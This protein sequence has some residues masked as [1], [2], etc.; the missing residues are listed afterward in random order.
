MSNIFSIHNLARPLSIVAFGPGG[1]DSNDQEMMISIAQADVVVAL[2]GVNLVRLATLLSPG[3][4]AL[5][6]LS[7]A[8]LP[9][10]PPDPFQ[11]L[12]GRNV[13]IDGWRI[14]GLSGSPL[15]AVQGGF[16][17]NDL[18]QE[19]ILHH[20]PSCDVLISATPPAGYEAEIADIPAYQSLRSWMD[21]AP[22]PFHLFGH[23]LND[24]MGTTP[25]GTLMIGVNRWLALPPF[26]PW[27]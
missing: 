22:P 27:R 4:Q 7:G 5:C 3:K 6:V 2:G 23:P 16:V 24:V 26:E 14:S 12:H 15:A 21:I 25:N 17:V 10:P 1:F 20:M 18:D 9:G 11:G 8:D 13:E 19:R